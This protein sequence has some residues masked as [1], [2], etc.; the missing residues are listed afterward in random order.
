MVISTAH[1]IILQAD[2]TNENRIGQMWTHH[3]NDVMI[4]LVLIHVVIF[5]LI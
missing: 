1:Y 4:N 5:K 3:A 2:A